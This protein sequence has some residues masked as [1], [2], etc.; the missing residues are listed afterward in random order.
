MAVEATRERI[1]EAA[2]RAFTHELY[3]EVTLRRIAADAGTALQTVVNHF[4]AKEDLFG[5][6]TERVGDSIEANRW[7]VVA[8][9]LDGAVALLV[10]DYER[11]ADF[12]LRML[13]LEDRVPVV[14]PSLERGRKGHEAWVEHAFVG[15][16]EGLQGTGRRRRLAQL[17]A[18]TDIYTWKIL[19]RDKGLDRDQT[20]TAMRELVSA[21]CGRSPGGL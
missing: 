11:T 4:G 21:L 7:Q 8:D 5:A 6:V 12:T 19:R 2:V 17:V 10:D 9:D 14:R 13:A 16:L 18:I 15:H 1:L 20:I 3:E